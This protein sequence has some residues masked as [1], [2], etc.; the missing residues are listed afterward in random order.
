MPRRNKRGVI[1]LETWQADL[2]AGL[3]RLGVQQLNSQ[4]NVLVEM[5]VHF[6]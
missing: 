3:R 1:R 2:H 5:P 6:Q 4:E